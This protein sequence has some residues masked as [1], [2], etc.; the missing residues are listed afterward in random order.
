MKKLIFIALSLWSLAPASRA[1]NYSID[2]YK[3]AG[4][5]GTSSGGSYY[6]SGTIG[7]SDAGGPMSGG[8]YSVTGGFWS[9]ISV[10]Q[11]PG[12]PNL[13]I[14]YSA[15]TA[16]ISWPDTGTYVLQQNIN[17]SSPTSWAASGLTVTASN[18]ANSVSITPPSG[19]LFFHLAA[20]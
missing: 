19:S 16:I 12:L 6:L 1:Q 5:G 17:L 4:G 20:P 10:V 15:N 8:K 18:G 13:T 11:T 3:I 9:L 14:T 2:W 7:Q